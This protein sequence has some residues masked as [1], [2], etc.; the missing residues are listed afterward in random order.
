M[1]RRRESFRR[2]GGGPNKENEQKESQKMKQTATQTETEAKNEE[3][4]D[5]FDERKRE[6]I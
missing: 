2:K 6:V 1:G 5:S 4:G 3:A